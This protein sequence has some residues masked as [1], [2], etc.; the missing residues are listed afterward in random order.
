[1]VHC[2]ICADFCHVKI[3]CL[4]RRDSGAG[5]SSLPDRKRHRS[6]LRLY[7]AHLA[8][9]QTIHLHQEKRSNLLKL[10]QQRNFSSGEI[11]LPCKIQYARSQ[12]LS[13]F[14]CPVRRSR[15][16]HDDFIHSV[17]QTLQGSGN[18]SLFIFRDIA[19]RYFHDALPIS[20]CLVIVI[21]RTK[22]KTTKSKKRTSPKGEVLFCS[23]CNSDEITGA[24]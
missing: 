12:H 19:S 5:A 24:G 3:L 4:D 14:S 15:I 9:R 8:V 22:L 10:L 16:D 20:S 13:N 17:C 23:L 1:M 21:S 11:V 6:P 2:E 7:C 18:I